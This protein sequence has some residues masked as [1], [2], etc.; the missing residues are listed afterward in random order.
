MRLIHKAKSPIMR[1]VKAHGPARA[2]AFSALIA[3]LVLAGCGRQNSGKDLSLPAEQLFNVTSALRQEPQSLHPVNSVEIGGVF[4]GMY[5]QRALT[6]QN[7][8]T[9]ATEPELLTALPAP[10]GTPDEVRLELRPDAKWDDGSQLTTED[11]DFTLKMTRAYATANEGRKDNYKNIVS[12]KLDSAN[13][14]VMYV[15]FGGPNYHNDDIFNELFIIRRKQWDPNGILDKISLE[16]LDSKEDYESLAADLRVKAFFT[17]FNS[18]ANGTLPDRI[19]GLGPYKI[20]EWNKGAYIIMEKKKNWWNTADS[21]QAMRPAKIIVRFIPEDE[22][23]MAE[24]EAGKL[25]AAEVG[26]TVF[27]K[28]QENEGDKGKFHFLDTDQFKYNAIALRTN[29]VNGVAILADPALRQALNLATD[30]DKLNTV[31]AGGRGRRQSSFIPYAQKDYYDSSIPLTKAD[32]RRA[33][34]LLAS[35]GWRDTNGDGIAEKNG[36][37][38]KL[39]FLYAA[40]P[41]NEKI[42]TMLR[43]MYADAGIDLEPVAAKDFGARLAA[44]DYD[45]ALMSLSV[46]AML[47]DPYMLFGKES[48]QGGLNL[49][50]YGNDASEKLLRRIQTELNKEKRV[51]LVKQLQ[52]E[53]AAQNHWIYLYATTAKFVVSKRFEEPKIYTLRPN[54]WLDELRPAQT[55]AA[56]P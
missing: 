43:D 44:R 35:A 40:A 33:R 10:T 15:R 21:A 42:I 54:L 25:D 46:S 19:N 12:V 47:E 34:A 32:A 53:V 6:R 2:T 52:K 55:A 38:L 26:G 22:T 17:D 37:P 9:L 8:S 23:I 49:T 56:N 14:R 1:I 3:L 36:R 48:I 5:T 18:A 13:N 45:M 24:L 28:M 30:V 41:A 16:N 11:V 7:P 4:F 20:T 51:A 31:L 29:P 39:R 27:R 50:G